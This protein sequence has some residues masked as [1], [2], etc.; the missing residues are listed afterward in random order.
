MSPGAP[1][2]GNGTERS[3][4]AGAL[5]PAFRYWRSGVSPW[6]AGVRWGSGPFHVLPHVLLLIALLALL[7]CPR[8][9]EPGDDFLLYTFRGS[10][11][12]T[13]FVAKV[14][15]PEAQAL[16][17]GE[18]E[19]VLARIEAELEG[20][21]RLMSTY[22]DD[23]ELSLFNRSRSTE[24]FPISGQTAEVLALALELGR[25]TGGALDVTIGPL[26]NAYGFGPGGSVADATAPLS[27]EVSLLEQLKGRVGLEYLVLEAKGAGADGEARVTKL[28]PELYVDLSSLA[29]GYAVDR[30]VEALA[31]DGHGDLM[32]EVGGEVRTAGLNL[33]RRA[34]R[35][36]VER[37][38]TG[39]DSM[40][41]GSVQRI[42]A[43]ENAAMATSGDYRNYRE[44]GGVRISHLV[45]PRNGL[46]IGHRL[47]SVTVVDESCMRADALAT[48]LMVLGPDEGYDFAVEHEL[49]VLFLVRDADRFLEKATPRFPTENDTERSSP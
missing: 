20:V 16:S 19:A 34:W 31:S 9:N 26:V 15:K 28:L 13:Y 4:T 43:L 46:P 18:Q 27:L 22:L 33:Q 40:A 45:D 24:P 47:A 30:V 44:V 49:A 29:K 48:A 35:M 39:S 12:G 36:G 23:S 25:L 5:A 8:E 37:P 7:G 42:V 1:N 41:L 6:R 14:V 11:M 21:N 17:E 10:T 32:V 2:P 38:V 3:T